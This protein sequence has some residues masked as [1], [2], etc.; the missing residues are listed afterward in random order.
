MPFKNGKPSGD[1]QPFYATGDTWVDVAVDP[2]D[3]S[4]FATQDET[5]M[6]YR[7]RY[8]GPA[9]TPV[10]PTGPAPRRHPW[11]ARAAARSAASWCYEMRFPYREVHERSVPYIL[12]RARRTWAQVGYPVTGELTE[13]LS[14][15]KTYTVQ[16][17]ERARFELGP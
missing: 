1:P 15:G 8:T 11:Q 10:P 9:P 14:D 17:T 5:G 16:Y 2:Y 7:I 6:I 13:Q 4:L 12:D 3:G